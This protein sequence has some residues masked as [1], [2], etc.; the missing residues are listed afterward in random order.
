MNQSSYIAFDRQQW[1]QLRKETPMPLQETDLARLHGE[2]EMVSLNE[3]RDIYL[4]LSRL[5]SY[6]VS[7]SQ[8]LQRATADFL[9]RPEPKVP[10][11]IGVAG[12][13]AVGKST[14]SRI[15]Q[16]L[17]SQWE[18]HP[19]VA[20]VPTDGFIYPNAY[21]EAN[22]LMA[23]KGFPESYDLPQLIQF[24]ADLKSGKPGLNVPI[25]S[26]HD[27]DIL[28]DQWQAVDQPDIVILEGLNILQTGAAPS[29]TQQQF[30]SDYLDFSIFVD[31]EPEIIEKWY[32]TRFESFRNK[33]MQDPSAYF[34]RFAQL[35]SEEATKMAMRYWHEI[36]LLNL[37]QNILPFKQ[38]AR[39]IL[40]KSEDHFVENV[41]LRKI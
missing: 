1:Q 29:E 22:D 20:L 4:P 9:S 16:A 7:A 34:H 27:Y 30:V 21:L 6:Y 35:N 18:H 39:L 23:R 13:V 28:P 32:L 33:A 38:R 31:A 11:I 26:H 24:L 5:L 41:Y 40:Q 25:Y 8:S 19:R 14:T 2:I 37:H 15:L 17:L 36:N 3:I 12:S 10:Y